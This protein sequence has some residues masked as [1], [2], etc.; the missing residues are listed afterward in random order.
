MFSGDVL[1]F[2]DWEAD[3]EDYIEDERLSEKEALR[4]LK[5]KFLDGAAKEV[6]SGLFYQ[7]SPEAY[8]E[9]RAKLKQRYGDKFSASR[10][11]RKKLSDWP[12]ISNKD[13][14]SLLRFADFL[15]NCNACMGAEDTT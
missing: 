14:D 3:L 7:N 6:V 1:Q 11:M 5:N 12:K 4:V 15:S 9:V 2:A 8:R 13:G 10:A